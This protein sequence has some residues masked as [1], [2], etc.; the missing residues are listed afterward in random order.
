MSDDARSWSEERKEAWCRAFDRRIADSYR[1]CLIKLP[2]LSTEFCAW[3]AG[4]GVRVG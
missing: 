3:M 4:L 1:V 2:P